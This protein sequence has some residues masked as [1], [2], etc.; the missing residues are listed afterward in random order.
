MYVISIAKLPHLRCSL[1]YNYE[2]SRGKYCIHAVSYTVVLEE[3]SVLGGIVEQVE[4]GSDSCGGG[5]CS[6][7]LSPSP[8]NQTY[9]V[10]VIA[11]N[12]LGPSEPALVNNTI[13]ML[14]SIS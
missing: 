14:L 6:I 3:D 9:R 8:S 10:S 1:S 2:I 13:C 7:S 4:V 5:I 12:I 11:A